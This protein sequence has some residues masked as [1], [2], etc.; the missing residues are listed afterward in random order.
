MLWERAE[1]EVQQTGD[2]S[3]DTVRAL[4]EFQGDPGI[5]VNPERMEELRSA[6]ARTIRSHQRL[7]SFPV[8][9]DVQPA[10]IFRRG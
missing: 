2:V 10:V 3:A 1:A 9:E 7:R 8:P 6:V 5:Y 4:L